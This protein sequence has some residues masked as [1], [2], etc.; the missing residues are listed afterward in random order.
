MLTNSCFFTKESVLKKALM[1]AT[2]ASVIDQFNDRNLEILQDMGYEVHVA[3]NFESGNTTSQERVYEYER[4][5]RNK[6]ITVHNITFP[7]DPKKLTEMCNSFR[8]LK[9]VIRDGK[10]DLVHCHTPVGGMLTRLICIPYR[11]RGMKVIYT[12]H[13]FH[14]YRGASLKCWLMYYPIEKILSRFTDVLITINDEDYVRARRGLDCKNIVKVPGI[15]IDPGKYRFS[16]E[17]KRQIRAEMR[18][19]LGLSEKDFVIIN[20]GELS[21]RKNQLL[22][23]KSMRLIHKKNVK[24][25]LTGIGVCRRDIMKYAY[26]H[27]LSKRVIFTGYREDIPKLLAMADCFVFT[28]I[29]EGLPVALMEAKACGLPCIVSRIRGNIDLIHHHF[30]GYCVESMSPGDWAGYIERMADKPEQERIDMGKRN[31]TDMDAYS[32]EAVDKCMRDIYEGV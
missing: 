6:G 5:L 12:A 15:G 2:V 13:G 32:C 1:V 19:E 24:L 25:V 29:Q 3:A 23:L 4:I 7:R 8:A 16:A 26:D 22:L 11:M 10:F 14:F 17:E 9:Q 21:I 31:M 20:V 28:S 27:R 30:G 18:E